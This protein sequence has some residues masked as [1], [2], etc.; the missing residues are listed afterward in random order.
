MSSI[1]KRIYEVVGI[2]QFGSN[3]L[4]F[5][6]P[7]LN[8]PIKLTPP[9]H[10]VHPATVHFPVA[11]LALANI[12]NLLYGATLYL[13]TSLPFTADK[14]NLATLAILAYSSN[15]LG[16]VTSIP[17]L[18]T[19][20]AELYAMVQANGLYQT[21]EKGVKSLIPKVKTTLT[22]V[23]ISPPFRF[24]SLKQTPSPNKGSETH[25][26]QAGLNDIVIV[27]AIYNWFVDR[28]VVDFKP[29]GHQIILSAGALFLAFYA[30]YLGGGLVYTRGV[31]VQRMGT[32][33]EIKK[34]QM[35][36]FAGKEK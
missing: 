24:S 20:F 36:E 5:P 10:P 12:L 31:G 11:F 15:V 33:A 21:D 29:A 9:S 34:R 32:G 6:P 1:A 35:E 14:E 18:V 27:S 22:H 13:P 25:T 26:P 2:G 8:C 28:N 19:G 7:K 4:V 17:A 16:I 23:R 30:A 3:R